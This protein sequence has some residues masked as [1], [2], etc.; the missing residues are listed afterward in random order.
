MNRTQIIQTLKKFKE[1]NKNRY[2]IQGL[3]I[4]GSFAKNCMKEDSD[5]DL[6]V[7]LSKQD[8]FES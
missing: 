4:F 6:V 3:G 5:I 7:N 2:H 1:E 8:L